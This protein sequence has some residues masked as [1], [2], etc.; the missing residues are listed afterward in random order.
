M[1]EIS[2]IRYRK[3]FSSSSPLS[4]FVTKAR[5]LNQ[6]AGLIVDGPVASGPGFNVG[7]VLSGL[8]RWRL[9][10]V[11]LENAAARPRLDTLD[12]VVGLAGCHAT[13]EARI[14]AAPG[15]STSLVQS[16]ICQLS[17]NVRQLSL[18]D[19]CWFPSQLT[20]MTPTVIATANPS[21]ELRCMAL[22][23][24]PAHGVDL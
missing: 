13:I 14:S 1:F 10:S 11:V 15:T 2:H 22:V 5:R 16:N 9:V 19:E 23:Q 3:P 7:I 8:R 17:N 20:W 21:P 24:G 12:K 4:G 18:L 6:W